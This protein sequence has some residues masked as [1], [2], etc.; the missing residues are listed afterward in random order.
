MHKSQ[1]YVH[2]GE[3]RTERH[4]N[5]VLLAALGS[6]VG[7]ALFDKTADVGGIAHLLL[8]APN[9]PGT[10]LNPKYYASTA[11]PLFFD[12]LLQKGA[13]RERLEAVIAGGSL[14]GPVSQADVL[15]DI[16]GRTVDIAI[17]FLNKRGIPIM[18]SETGGCFG[19]RL[20]VDT[21]NWRASIEPVFDCASTTRCLPA[22]KP[23][24]EKVAA[25]I[26]QTQPIPQIALKIIRLLRTGNY[27]FKGLGHEIQKDQVLSAKVIHFC[28]SAMLGAR[29]SF[30]SMDQ[31]LIFLGETSLLEMVVSAAIKSFFSG[32]RGG[33]A[34]MRGGL[35][36]HAL[37]VAHIA[38]TIAQYRQQED[39]GNVYTAGLLH[40][41]GKV[42]LDAF[43]VHIMPLFYQHEKDLD[44]GF[45]PLEQEALGIDHQEVGRMLAEKWLL[46]ENLQEIIAFHHTPALATPANR[47]LTHTVALADLLASRFLAGVEREK[48][49]AISLADHLKY[50]RLAPRDLP[51]II[52]RVPWR[53]ITLGN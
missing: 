48:I 11:L 45:V 30:D 42:V 10:P 2:S 44:C 24:R 37:A 13:G 12:E 26:E 15:L 3:Y 25:S 52:G 22:Q 5:T 43:F 34:L 4:G 39:N 18:Q 6:C 35:F 38:K 9:G 7:V 32:S 46:P 36:S 41:I 27:N 51:R 47:E 14:F 23:S 33:Y 19:S 29:T 40:D 20:L 31:C 21:S 17:D 50:L 28:N 8:P 53:R 1:K 16:G 49:P